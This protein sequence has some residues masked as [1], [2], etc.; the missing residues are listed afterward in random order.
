MRWGGIFDIESKKIALEEEELRTQ[1][2]DFW[3]DAKS[4]EEQ[5]KKVR[6]LK[7]WLNGYAEVASATEEASLAFDFYK[8]NADYIIY[9][10]SDE[11]T[12]LNDFEKVLAEIFK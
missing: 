5:M 9:N 3:N 6:A 1:S 12:F 7:Y 8:E 11:K 10:N 2:P 4:A